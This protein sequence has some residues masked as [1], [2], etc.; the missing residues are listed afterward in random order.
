MTEV[1][2]SARAYER[3]VGRWSRLVARA[4]IAWLAAPPQAAWLDVGCGTGALSEEIASAAAPARVDGIDPSP[5][6]I[7]E[8]ASRLF[9]PLFSFQ[10]GD[11][12]ELPHPNST[13]DVVASALVLTFLPDAPAGAREMV[14]VTKPGGT[15]ASY[16]WDY[17]GEMQM[18]KYFWDVAI[19]LLP[20][21]RE[22]H[23]GLR[24]S[25]ARPEELASLFRD[26][27][28]SDIGTAPLEIETRFVD[29]DDYWQ[30]FLGGQGPAPGYVTSLTDYERERLRDALKD[31]LPIASD[32]SIELVAKAW[33]VRGTVAARAK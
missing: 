23:E 20:S 6:F 29:F 21:A 33:A 8:T 27:G 5:A 9:A 7:D 31:R 24:F 13:Y 4:F 18:M 26:A 1:W 10:V 22:L 28:L 25:L 11:A 3:Y 17:S 14:R 2:N 19:E 12:L 16:V 30:P 32:G 15:V